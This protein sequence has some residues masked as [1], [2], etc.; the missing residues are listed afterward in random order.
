MK[1]CNQQ[2]ELLFDSFY[3]WLKL[4]GLSAQ[5]SE[6]LHKR[7]IHKNLL[8]NHRMTVENFNEFYEQESQKQYFDYFAKHINT[9][10]GLQKIVY[11]QFFAE[12]EGSI[13]IELANGESITSTIQT[14]QNH[15]KNKIEEV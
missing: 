1:I 9:K 7:K 11:I 2:K 4:N 15:I 10:K 12:E 6:L 5:K 3:H 13:K 14:L 8:S